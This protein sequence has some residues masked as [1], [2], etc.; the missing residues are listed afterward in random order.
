MLHFAANPP[1]SFERFLEICKDKIAD[2]DIEVIKLAKEA[3][4]Y[5]G[6]QPTLKRWC[7][8]EVALRN[9]LVK[10][11]AGR[12]HIDPL[13][14]IR[15]DGYI[16]PHIAHIA[17]N[18]CRNPAILEAE[19][20][21]DQGRWGALDELAVGHYFDL[22]FLLTYALKLLILERWQRI[23]SADKPSLLNGIIN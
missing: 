21:L 12:K 20:G 7:A 11:R 2:E 22:D 16:E 9:E 14:Y 8:F 23:N 13:K 10:I 17:M 4:T 1:F 18:A 5:Q 15:G 3:Y 6:E 19:K